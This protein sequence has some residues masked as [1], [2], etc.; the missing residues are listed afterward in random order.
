M[1][2][3]RAAARTFPAIVGRVRFT[4]LAF[5]TGTTVA[6]LRNAA[7]A[8][9]F[10]M[11]AWLHSVMDVFDGYWRD[12]EKGVYEHITG[13]WIK[14]RGWVPYASLWEW[15]LQSLSN[16]LAIG[17][18]PHLHTLFL[19][20]VENRY[21]LLYGNWAISAMYEALIEAPRRIKIEV[22]IRRQIESAVRG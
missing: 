17:I 8:A 2:K 13:R 18:S 22:E 6:V 12:P 20:G 5:S 10:S 11:G 19:P 16:V 3:R 7:C 9:C 21:T 1:S 14:P 4:N 15:V